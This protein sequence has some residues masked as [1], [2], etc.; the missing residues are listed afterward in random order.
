MTGAQF[1]VQVGISSLL[2]HIQTGSGAHISWP[3]HKAD[4][5]PPSSGGAVKNVWSYISTPPICLHY[6]VLN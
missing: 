6:V 1:V 3:E 5:K 2:H 4:H